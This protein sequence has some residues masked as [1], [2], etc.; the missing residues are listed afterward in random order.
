MGAQGI[1]PWIH[2]FR[3]ITLFCFH[4]HTHTTAWL[5]F[6]YQNILFVILIIWREDM[7]W[8]SVRQLKMVWMGKLWHCSSPVQ[9]FSSFPTNSS[10]HPSLAWL[11]H[12]PL[13]LWFVI[14]MCGHS[15]LSLYFFLYTA[16]TQSSLCCSSL[17]ANVQDVDNTT[18]SCY[19]YIWCLWRWRSCEREIGK[20]STGKMRNGIVTAEQIFRDFLYDNSGTHCTNYEWNESTSALACIHSSSSSLHYATLDH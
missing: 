6:L 8:S 20:R 4:F 2:Y 10:S 12:C 3:H 7:K 17:V 5:M 18:N 16:F 19:M 15:H 9:K 14:I 1:H 11:N 13:T